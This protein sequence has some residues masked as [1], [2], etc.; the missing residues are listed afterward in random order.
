MNEW[1]N[2]KRQLCMVNP[3]LCK[4]ITWE[5]VQALYGCTSIVRTSTHVPTRVMLIVVYTS[6][7]K[8]GCMH[9]CYGETTKK[10]NIFYVRKGY[11]LANLTRNVCMGTK[12]KI[13]WHQLKD[14]GAMVRL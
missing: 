7:A 2:V 14:V 4:P 1:W 6:V 10:Q 9:S 3:A 5:H 11:D 13:L 8:Q 12:V